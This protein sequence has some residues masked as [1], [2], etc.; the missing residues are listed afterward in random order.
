MNNNLSVEICSN[1]TQLSCGPQKRL[2]EPGSYPY[3]ISLYIFPF[4]FFIGTFG[5]LMILI[6]LK[7]IKQN[8][9][10]FLSA[11]ALADLLF[12]IPMFILSLNAYDSLADKE[13]FMRFSYHSHTLVVAIANS[14][15]TSSNW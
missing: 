14:F 6:I 1:K 9:K 15:S 13:N 2:P 8:G 5:N 10:L 12:F 7:K 4:L 3:Y 11:M